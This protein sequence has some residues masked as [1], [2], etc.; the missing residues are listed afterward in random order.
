MV[1]PVTLL[2]GAG[3]FLQG[4][5]AVGGLFG[6]RGGPDIGA[7]QQFSMQQLN[8]QQEFA[9]EMALNSIQMRVKDA[10][11]AGVSPLVALGAPTYSPS[12]SVGGVD[13]GASRGSGPDFRGLQSFGAG[14]GDLAKGISQREMAEGMLTRQI[15][16]DERRGRLTD[17]DIALKGAQ[18][19]YWSKMA[20]GA[21]GATVTPNS[22]GLAGQQ[23]DRGF[24]A[25][26]EQLPKTEA[27]GTP[28]EA[29][30]A[31]PNSVWRQVDEARVV[32]VPRD[33][34]IASAS[35]WNP[36]Y[37]KWMAGT[38]TAAPPPMSALPPGAVRWVR[39][40][41]N[42][43]RATSYWPWEISGEARSRR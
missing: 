17:A 40:G 25:S 26:R 28:G 43:W 39:D 41:L 2:A 20:T 42:Q 5:G 18:A 24:G 35:P 37:L 32:R 11:A 36:E 30:G 19:A 22:G 27:F 13:Y 33:P 23:V 6:G 10:Q 31:G 9:R 21:N 29:S 34:V 1:D 15:A 14:L 4:V 7:Q 3:S 8:M 16:E 38:A 12:L